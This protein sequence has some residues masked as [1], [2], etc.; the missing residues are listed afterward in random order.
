MLRL[1]LQTA[2]SAGVEIC[3][4]RDGVIFVHSDVV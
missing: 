2:S 3:Q 1:R 4:R